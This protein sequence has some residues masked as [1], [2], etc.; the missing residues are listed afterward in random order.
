MSESHTSYQ[1]AKRW[2]TVSH[3]KQFLLLVASYEWVE[4]F[5]IWS[6]KSIIITTSSVFL[7]WEYK[8]D[9]WSPSQ[10]LYS[11]T[12]HEMDWGILISWKLS[13][14]SGVRRGILAA[15][16]GFFVCD[17][18]LDLMAS[19]TLL[20][21]NQ[22]LSVF[23]P[24]QWDTFIWLIVEWGEM[25]CVW[26]FWVSGWTRRENPHQGWDSGLGRKTSVRLK[27]AFSLHLGTKKGPVLFYYNHPL[28]YN[29]MIHQENYHQDKDKALE[30]RIRSCFIEW[31]SSKDGL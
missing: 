30:S 28:F 12:C 27:W 17:V 31:P 21:A 20:S 18:C 10:T 13:I 22:R 24:D 15:D 2:L 16:C 3:K 5:P 25:K 26:Y 4:A 14:L 9:I 23:H 6:S 29:L 8:I 11:V 19:T 7:T 1:Q